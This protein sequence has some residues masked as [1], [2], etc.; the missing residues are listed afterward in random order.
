MNIGTFNYDGQ[1]ATLIKKEKRLKN[2]GN[3][4]I[5]ATFDNGVIFVYTTTPNGFENMDTNFDLV[6]QPSGY[7]KS[8]LSSPKRDFHDY[9]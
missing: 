1:D 5:R 2:N 6:M 9:Y 8:D 3:T 4:V 7:Y